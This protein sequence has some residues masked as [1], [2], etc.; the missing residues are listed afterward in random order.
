[1]PKTK[2]GEKIT[3]SEFF[4]RWGKGIEGI[5]P[6][7]KLKTQLIGTLITL[8]GL[9]CGLIISIIAWNKLWWVGI[10][11][12]GAILTTGIQYLGFKQQYTQLKLLENSE[13]VN[14]E[15]L[16]KE[17]KEEEVNKYGN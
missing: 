10:V 9:F 8:I 3:W 17:V 14:L 16:F 2:A 5:T 15:E 4:K 13:E 11:L 12:I 6:I 7:Q 1:M